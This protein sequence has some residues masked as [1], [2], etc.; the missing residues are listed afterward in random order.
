MQVFRLMGMPDKIIAFDELPEELVKGFE[1]IKAE[2]FPRYWKKWIG[3]REIVTPIPPE[4]NAI[5]GERR[6]F[7]PIVEKDSYFYLVDWGIKTSVE[8][9]KKI[10][11]YVR[12]K[13]A[14]D[15]RLT[16]KLEDMAKPLAPNK[17]EGITLEP[18]D[19]VVIPVP[20]EAPALITES[21]D[22]NVSRGTVRCEE[23][24]CDREFDGAYAQNAL[25]MHMQKKHKK[26]EIAA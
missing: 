25:R 21:K 17:T 8:K 20:K 10:E 6:T 26:Q 18:D 7:P 2:G 22:K 9:W 5:T 3:E 1:L 23:K 12:N 16:D 11:E 15:F 19:V 14:S 24:D 13:V 4:M